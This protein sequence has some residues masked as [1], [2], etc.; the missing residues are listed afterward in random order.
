MK[1]LRMLFVA[2]S[3]GALVI[4]SVGTARAQSG[5]VVSGEL[6]AMSGSQFRIVGQPGTYS[7]PSG[8][9]IQALDGKTVDVEIATGGRVAQISPHPVPINPVTHGWSTVRGQLAVVDPLNGRFTFAGDNQTYVAPSNVNIS[10]YAGRMVEAKIDENGNVTEL[11][12]VTGV[13]EQAVIPAAPAAGTCSYS[14]QI[15]SAGAAV[16]QSG[17]QYRCDGTHWQSLG[18]ACRTGAADAPANSGAVM[19]PRSCGVGDA[20]V[21]TGSSI[22]RAGTTYRCD[23]G[24]WISLGT[25]C[26]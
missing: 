6:V 25:P 16:C 24:A 18:T 11:R 5:R 9:D 4:V 20:T 12:P 8:V 15:Y 3:L 23:D 14:G 13:S 7:A 2:T 22:C 10:S 17:T 26:R 19:S 1:L 21:A